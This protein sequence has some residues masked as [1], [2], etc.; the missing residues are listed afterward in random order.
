M[1]DK[2]NLTAYEVYKLRRT[3]DKRLIAGVISAVGLFLFPP[4][5]FAKP[6]LVTAKTL[7]LWL[8]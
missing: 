6:A 8:K 4:C 2:K 5:R 3:Y 1:S 7:P